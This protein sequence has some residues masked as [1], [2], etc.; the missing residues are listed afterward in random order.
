MG[1]RLYVGNLSFQATSESVRDAFAQN[2]EL[3]MRKPFRADELIAGV[4]ALVKRSEAAT[5]A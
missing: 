1:N 3:V 4:E 2:V 5:P